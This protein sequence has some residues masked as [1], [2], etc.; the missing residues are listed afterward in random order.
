M[1]EAGVGP[2]REVHSRNGLISKPSYYY[3]TIIRYYISVITCHNLNRAL[4]PRQT[5]LTFNFSSCVA[6]ALHWQSVLQKRCVALLQTY[7]A[8]NFCVADLQSVLQK[9]CVTTNLIGIG[10]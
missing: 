8:F 10:G 2:G 4:L 1:I 3:D 5:Y 9:R 7:L 6:A